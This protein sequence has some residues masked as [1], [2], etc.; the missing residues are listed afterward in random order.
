M[1]T[2]LPE[3]VQGAGCCPLPSPSALGKCLS[4]CLQTQSSGRHSVRITGVSSINF[5]ASFSTQPDPDSIQPG[6]RPLQGEAGTCHDVHSASCSWEHGWILLF[7][8]GC[9]SPWW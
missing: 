8:Q 1:G 7:S 9:P 3:R 6:E 2:E 4:S 5:Q